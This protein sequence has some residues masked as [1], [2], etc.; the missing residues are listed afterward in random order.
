VIDEPRFSRDYLDPEKR[1]IA[2]SLQVFFDDGSSTEK[3]EIEY[4]L[5]HP[6]RREDALPLLVR[7]CRE[8]LSSRFT[9]DQAS[10]FTDLCLDADRLE[11]MAV[12]EFMEMLV[13]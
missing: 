2:N 8:N 4:P 9:P 3:V 7:K 6:R 13:V 10:D 12:N 11:G 1:S 5:G